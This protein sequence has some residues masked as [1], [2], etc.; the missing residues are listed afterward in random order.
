MSIV[1]S[2]S[3]SSLFETINSWKF[4]LHTFLTPS[5]SLRQG[6]SLSLLHFT[7]VSYTFLVKPFPKVHMARPLKI[8]RLVSVTSSAPH[9]LSA[10]LFNLV[11]PHILRKNLL[12]KTT[13]FYLLYPQTS[14]SRFTCH[15]WYYRFFIWLPLHTES[16]TPDIKNCLLCTKGFCSL[17]NYQ[18]NTFIRPSFP[19]D[20]TSKQGAKHF[21]ISF[22]NL[23]LK[24]FNHNFL[25]LYTL[26]YYVTEYLR[27]LVDSANSA[28]SSANN[29]LFWSRSLWSPSIISTPFPRWNFISFF[30][31]STMWL[32]D[33]HWDVPHACLE[34]ICTMKHFS[35]L[36]QSRHMHYSVHN[37]F[38][39]EP[40]LSPFSI[41]PQYLVVGYMTKKQM[42]ERTCGLK[43]NDRMDIWP[44]DIWP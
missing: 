1:C 43:T 25:L 42:A 2:H 37:F 11:F 22:I 21:L 12:F 39:C 20:T 10:L 7:S 15:R 35:Q 32:F 31:H 27:L 44:E 40:K 19:N 38:L 33:N 16:C 3:K 14:I 4:S 13:S 8:N 41:E 26:P 29:S 23:V 30:Y 6:S 34:L 18:K 36:Q 17:L 24:K 9:F 28:I 5:S